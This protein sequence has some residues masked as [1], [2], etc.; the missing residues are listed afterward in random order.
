MSLSSL[1]KP[2]PYP[3]APVIPF[4]TPHSIPRSPCGKQSR[5][6]ETPLG[7]GPRG[8][9]PGPA[10]HAVRG[11]AQ[12]PV[13]NRRVLSILEDRGLQG[14]VTDTWRGDRAETWREVGGS[15]GHR[16]CVLGPQRGCRRAYR[17][18]PPVLPPSS[19]SLGPTRPGQGWRLTW[20]PA[21]AC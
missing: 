4:Q 20:S 21:C 10:P 13:S 1:L 15:R 5:D 16:G 8:N 18:R 19:A 12:H 7:P 3:P 6:T 2:W 14:T 11:L 17:C 9:P